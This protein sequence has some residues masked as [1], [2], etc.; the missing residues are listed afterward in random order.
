MFCAELLCRVKKKKRASR[1]ERSL[2]GANTERGS[3][4]WPRSEDVWYH[5]IMHRDPPF[6]FLFRSLLNSCRLSF[7]SWRVALRRYFQTV[8][9]CRSEPCLCCFVM[10]D[11]AK[12]DFPF[13]FSQQIIYRLRSCHFTSRS[14]FNVRGGQR[15]LSSVLFVFVC[16]CV[17]A[18]AAPETRARPPR[19][20]DD[21]QC[22]C[23][24]SIKSTIDKQQREASFICLGCSR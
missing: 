13:F 2:G 21:Q 20:Y 5:L 18:C 23:K 22:C 19:S 14:H 1:S 4:I 8:S 6:L 10:T 24:D 16:V 15:V 3:N 12:E 9:R 11:K 7:C 17:Y